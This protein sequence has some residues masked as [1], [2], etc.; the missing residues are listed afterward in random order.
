VIAGCIAYS[1]LRRAAYLRAAEWDVL[2]EIDQVTGSL[3]LTDVRLNYVVSGLEKEATTAQV[4]EAVNLVDALFV[5]GLDEDAARAAIADS[6]GDGMSAAANA[7]ELGGASKPNPTSD[8]GRIATAFEAL[9]NKGF[10]ARGHFVD[11]DNCAA[12]R[13]PDVLPR[14][15]WTGNDEDDAFEGNRLVPEGLYLAFHGGPEIDQVDAGRKIVRALR[16]QKLRVTW[17]GDP[18]VKIL[19]RSPRKWLGAKR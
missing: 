4:D 12:A 17:A 3:E 11:C 15:W 6:G 14:V 5:A 7:S 1:T 18:A 8:R 16:E 9:R 19:V 2:G 10:F 13:A